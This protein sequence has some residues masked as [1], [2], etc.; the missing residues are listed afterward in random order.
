MLL[1]VY[2]IIII[3]IFLLS[4]IIPPIPIKLMVTHHF[5]DITMTYDVLNW[6]IKDEFKAGVSRF[7]LQRHNSW[8][9]S[10]HGDRYSYFFQKH[11]WYSL[12]V[13][14]VSV[15]KCNR[16]SGMSNNVFLRPGNTCK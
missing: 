2:I 5:E 7:F 9:Y 3:L 6:T 8:N 16:I 1:C 4:E 13:S 11:K 15:D 12:S 10:I 14:I